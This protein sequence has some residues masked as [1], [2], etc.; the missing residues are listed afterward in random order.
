MGTWWIDLDD[1]RLEH[2]ATARAMLGHEPGEGNATTAEFFSTVHPSDRPRAVVAWDDLRHRGIPLDLEHRVIRPDGSV[3]WI[4]TRGTR[5]DDR[6]TRR[7]RGTVADITEQHELQDRL[8]ESQAA[9]ERGLAELESVYRSAPVGLGVLDPD[10]RF[11]RVNDRLAAM[12]GL[13]VSDH[14]GRTI[15]EVAP[16]LADSVEPVLSRVLGGESVL[17]VEVRGST[18]ASPTEARI[19]SASYYPITDASG[20]VIAI[21]KVAEDITERTRI[22][23]ELARGRDRMHLAMRAARMFSF[24]RDV[25]TNAIVRSEECTAILGPGC[26]EVDWTSFIGSVHD[27][28]RER[29]VALVRKLTPSQSHYTTVYR[30]RRPDGAMVSLEET[31][32][33]VFDAGGALVHLYGLVADVSARETMIAKLR[34]SQ[35]TL[36]L[37]TSAVP[38]ML[39]TCAPSG[40]CDYVNHWFFEFIGAD[41]DAR[42][43]GNWLDKVDER[44]R[45]ATRARWAAAVDAGAPFGAELRFRAGDGTYRWFKVQAVPLDGEGG[46]VARWIGV[47]SDIDSVKRAQEELRK[48]D[49]RKDEF[50]AMLA[51]ELRN[52]LAPVLN[53][54]NTLALL[55]H[56]DPT[57]L[58]VTDVIARQARH[59]GRL[60][61]DLLE[62]SRITAGR[63]R[64]RMAR[65]DLRR[66]VSE[67]A[68]M[69]RPLFAQRMQ[70]LELNL[71]DAPLYVNADATRLVQA[72]GNLL[73]NASKYTP[74]RG[75]IAIDAWTVDQQAHI[76]V[77]DSGVGMDPELIE[78]VFDLFTQGT[79]ALD[80]AQG[81]LGIGLALVR[82]IAE[83]HGGGV[84]AASQGLGQGSRFDLWLPLAAAAGEADAEPDSP[85]DVPAEQSRGSGRRV[86]VVDDNVDAAEILAKGLTLLGHEVRVSFEGTDALAMAAVFRPD[87][88]ILD[89]GLPGLDGFEVARR[90]RTLD[91]C[92]STRLIALTGYGQPEH[93]HQSSAAGFE[94]HLVKPV[95]LQELATVIDA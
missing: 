91:G 38:A 20:S 51:H 55:T 26:C 15:R 52:P 8:R 67:A 5:A 25:R 81:G 73:N 54:V 32:R 59:M 74:D 92:E 65:L 34:E 21:N 7:A 47:A 88:A 42:A 78:G 82:R 35:A 63:I 43:L 90:L 37:L 1:D 39:F 89:L 94:R 12:H 33:G 80:R 87:V 24:E 30:M 4:R 95:E 62:V 29:L 11:V 16:G 56:D 85:G 45:D 77:R 76:A 9:A 3:R 28:D 72:L 44:D 40:E 93:K 46:G 2:D 61:D 6:G 48:A 31:A 49:R 19:W 27:D 69:N 70:Q 84:S 17:D 23:A 75:T 58:R 86:L 60:L 64:L 18:P 66:A 50:L 53:A 14:I 57:L 83:L 79:Q 10:L 68:D 22:M 36:A 71:P 13:P 41:A